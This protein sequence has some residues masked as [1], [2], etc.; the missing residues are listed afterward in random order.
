MSEVGKSTFPDKCVKESIPE[1]IET[2]DLLNS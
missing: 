1:D 2:S